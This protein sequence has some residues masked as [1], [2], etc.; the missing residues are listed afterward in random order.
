MARERERERY[1]VIH[2]SHR[3]MERVRRGERERER[4]S[5]MNIKKARK[6]ER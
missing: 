1:S 6:R 2:A 4:G 5:E 3:D